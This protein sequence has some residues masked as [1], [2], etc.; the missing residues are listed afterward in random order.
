MSRPIKPPR[1]VFIST[2]ILFDSALTP[3]LRD[4]LLQ[5]YALAWGSDGQFTPPVSI[6]QLVQLTGK[7][8][9]SLYA[10][11][12]ALRNFHSAL[13]LQ[14]AGSGLFVIHFA[15]WLLP[16]KSTRL[17]DCRILQ[18]PDHKEDLTVPEDSMSLPLP[19]SLNDHTPGNC[20]ISRKL[21]RK[22]TAALRD[23]GI[24]PRLLAEVAES[25]YRDA[26]LYALLAWAQEDHPGSEAAAVF[27]G[28]MRGQARPPVRFY[29][30]PCP[31][32]GRRGDHTAE[33]PRRILSGPYA[34][35][36]EH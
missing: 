7:S 1:G 13:R 23:A 12:T 4:T 34:E 20:K 17:E 10:H 25:G 15:E 28:R 33:C 26:D 27:I 11:L 19:D 8:E 5:L 9:R 6:P 29:E 16:P 35:Y 36:L 32:C 22:L 18:L 30:S 21:P 3:T 31:R 2:T 24:F 14:G